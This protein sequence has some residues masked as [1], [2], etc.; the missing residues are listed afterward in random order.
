M[1][2]N[3]SGN[4]ITT[5]DIVLNFNST[6]VDPGAATASFEVER[7]SGSAWTRLTSGT[8]TSTSTEAT[9]VNQLGVFAVGEN[10][11][12]PS[13]NT[14]I[15]TDPLGAVCSPNSITFGASANS[16]PLSTAVWQIKIN[17]DFTNLTIASPYSV[18]TSST[19]N[20]TTSELRVDPT[21]PSLKGKIYRVVFTNNKGSKPSSEKALNFCEILIDVAILNPANFNLYVPNNAPVSYSSGP[22]APTISV[23]ADYAP[24]GL[25]TIILKDFTAGASEDNSEIQIPYD[26]EINIPLVNLKVDGITYEMNS[27][28]FVIDP[29]NPR[30]VTF[31][32][33]KPAE[34]AIVFNTNLDHGI[35]CH[36]PD[37]FTISIPSQYSSFFP[38]PNPKLTITELVTNTVILSDYQG[39]IW[40]SSG[41]NAGPYQYV[42]KVDYYDSGNTETIEITGQ[43]IVD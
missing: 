42:L 16:V 5:F 27:D 17:G 7:Y 29:L 23:V 37:D 40:S 19:S 15:T 1:D 8:R 6:E 35:A 3:R 10:G 34:Q 43:F 22:D 14:D 33:N 26:N 28:F 38:T 12:S 18:Q 32:A 13:I 25:N 20:T 24:S 11:A 30:H 36:T 21:N 31:Y 2:F 4:N 9:S 41:A 39:Y